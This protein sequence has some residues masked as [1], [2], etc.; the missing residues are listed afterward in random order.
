MSLK[1]VGDPR[2]DSL[3]LQ[4]KD[5]YVLSLQLCLTVCDPI[6]CSPLGYSVH[7]T[8]QARILEWIAMPSS[9]GSS[10]P[11][12]RTHISYLLWSPVLADRFF[13]FSAT[14][15]ACKIKIK[16]NKFIEHLPFARQL[17]KC[18]WFKSESHLLSILMGLIPQCR[19]NDKAYRWEN[20]I[21]YHLYVEPTI[22]HKWTY[23]WN[24]NRD[25]D[26]ENRPVVAQGQDEGRDELGVWD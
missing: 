4:N 22:W 26:K 2:Q 21:C 6:N 1:A 18:Q 20:T 9:R 10:W 14:W 23:L 12:E 25:T 11:R 8:M 17:P 24:R 13:T 15:E 5:A 16:L 7:G 3:P 19:D